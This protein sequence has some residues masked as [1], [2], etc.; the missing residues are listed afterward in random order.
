MNKILALL[1]LVMGLF[2]LPFFG[3]G[4]PVIYVSCRELMK[5]E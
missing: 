3:A 1:G 5:E 2:F 4:I